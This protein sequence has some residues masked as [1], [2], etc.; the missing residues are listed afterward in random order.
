MPYTHRLGMVEIPPICDDLGYNW[1]YHVNP[2]NTSTI[3]L[4]QIS[5]QE[6]H[7]GFKRPWDD[8]ESLPLPLYAYISGNFR[9][10]SN[11]GTLVYHHFSGHMNCEDVPLYT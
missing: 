5:L 6:L 9:I 3:S 11:G 2:I 10:R 4:V 8:M 7:H 1:V